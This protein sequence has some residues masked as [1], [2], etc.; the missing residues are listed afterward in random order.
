MKTVIN[1][2]I[3]TLILAIMGQLSQAQS[4]KRVEI[5]VP[6]NSTEVFTIPLNQQGVI[7]LNQINKTNYTLT[8][9]DTNLDRL[10]TVNGTMD[11]TLDYVKHSYDGKNLYLLFSRYRSN[12]YEVVKVNIGP[13]FIEKYQIMSVDRMEVSDFQALNSS[14]FIGGVVN[15]QPVIL[16][17]NLNERKTKVLPSALKNQAEIQSMELDTT[18]EILNVTYAVG[19]KGKNYQLVLK[20]FDENGKQIS[21]V[22]MNPDNEFAMMNGRLNLVSDSTEVMFGTYGHKN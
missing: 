22:A 1:R 13:G 15:S 4:V 10:W 17:T 14:V 21:Q 2:T 7:V 18:S 11:A 8:R 5:P 6:S 16:F 3:L 9:Y 19:T 20:S 12:V